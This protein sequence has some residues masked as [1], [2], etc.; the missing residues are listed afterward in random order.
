M[1]V[2]SIFENN[3]VT[4][5]FNDV[6]NA[7]GFFRDFNSHFSSM[8]MDV[9]ELDNNYELSMELPGFKKEDIHAQL[10]DGYLVIEA[11]HNQEDS[12]QDNN[13]KY[14][15][16]ERYYGSCQRNIYV[17]DAVKEED[18]HASFENGILKLSVP[19]NNEQTK[20]EDNKYIPIA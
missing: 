6:F 15:R 19:K 20:I 10:K 8:N 4:N 1:L 14:I 2:P 11:S 17:G 9:Q 7:N 3:T 16:R 12:Q 13:G 5:L 18:I